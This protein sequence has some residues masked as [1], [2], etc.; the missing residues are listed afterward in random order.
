MTDC[1][2]FT[3]TYADAEIID[4]GVINAVSEEDGDIDGADDEEKLSRTEEDGK[5][6]CDTDPL[7]KA[8]TDKEVNE[9]GDTLAIANRE[10]VAV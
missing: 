7:A 9:D 6:V 2:I 10:D 4:N 8:D 1:V 3:V 5:L